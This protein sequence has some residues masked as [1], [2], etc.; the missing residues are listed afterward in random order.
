MHRAVLAR[1]G[2]DHVHT[3]H[4]LGAFE[5]DE[6]GVRAYF[7]DPSGARRLRMVMS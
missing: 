3:G 6:A 5:Q 4:R 2:E 1:L 7:F